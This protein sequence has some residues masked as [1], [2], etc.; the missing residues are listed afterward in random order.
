M[1]VS[2]VFVAMEVEEELSSRFLGSA[3]PSEASTDA[4]PSQLRP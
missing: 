2:M 4:D 3:T 1:D